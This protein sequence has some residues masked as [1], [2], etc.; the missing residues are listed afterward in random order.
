MKLTQ[1]QTELRDDDRH[2]VM[3]FQ[4]LDPAVP[5]VPN[6]S[7]RK[8][9]TGKTEKATSQPHS[10]YCPLNVRSQQASRT[11]GRQLPLHLYLV[12]ITHTPSKKNPYSSTQQ[13]SFKQGLHPKKISQFYSATQFQAVLF[14]LFSFI[15]KA[16][17]GH[18]AHSQLL[19]NIYLMFV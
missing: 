4:H 13:L 9:F 5:E 19:G 3:F 16:Q 17:L 11:A 15:T 14:F 10:P 1:I 7:F 12:F 8:S 6:F 2:L 18:H